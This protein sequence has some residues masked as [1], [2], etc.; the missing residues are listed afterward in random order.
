MR[1]LILDC[2]P[3]HD[4]ALAILLAARHLEVLGITT[5]AG[6]QTLEKVTANALKIVEFTKR[7]GSP[8]WT[9]FATGLESLLEEAHIKLSSLVSDVLRTSARRMLQALADGETQISNAAQE[10][11]IADLAHCLVAMG[12]EIERPPFRGRF[13]EEEVF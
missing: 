1:K 3:G 5:V 6:N 7:F 9:I 11:E 4:D 12:A 8:P 10:P 13:G 2:D